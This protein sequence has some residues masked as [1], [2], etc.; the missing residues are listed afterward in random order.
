MT[1]SDD[2]GID[3]LVYAMG[4]LVP[5]AQEMSRRLNELGNQ[6]TRTASMVKELVA[7]QEVRRANGEAM[8][9]L[10]V[11]PTPSGTSNWVYDAF[12]NAGLDTWAHSG[13]RGGKNYALTMASVQI[14][15]RH[16][17]M[18]SEDI[19]EAV[20]QI[21]S[22]SIRSIS[23]TATML[24]HILESE[25]SGAYFSMGAMEQFTRG[26]FLLEVV[27]MLG[28]I[29]HKK[30]RLFIKRLARKLKFRINRCKEQLVE[31]SQNSKMPIV[32]T[33]VSRSMFLEIGTSI[34]HFSAREPKTIDELVE[35]ALSPFFNRRIECQ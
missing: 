15:R 17:N 29:E 11:T 16:I 34:S 22:R 13:R 2:H 20:K 4:N 10:R 9:R 32:N 19:F 24:Q 23:D 26:T 27:E 1:K 25:A 31:A 30:T 28:S 5:D 14:I 6:W 3:A 12:M 35:E 33:K 21:S 18:S 8:K 7:N